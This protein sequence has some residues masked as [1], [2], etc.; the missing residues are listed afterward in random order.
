VPV[1][2]LPSIP[3][4]PEASIVRKTLAS[5]AG[6]SAWLLARS[7]WALPTQVPYAMSIGGGPVGTLRFTFDQEVTGACRYLASWDIGG[8]VPEEQCGVDEMITFGNA[9]CERNASGP[10][11]SLVIVSVGVE[12]RG[13]D[14]THEDNSVFTLL[15]VEMEDGSLEGMIQFDSA[16]APVSDVYAAPLS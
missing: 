3:P 13:F 6:L 4:G 7:V 1:A 15:L 5:L 10:L 14:G 12:C 8:G 11:L 2:L 9:D 16:D